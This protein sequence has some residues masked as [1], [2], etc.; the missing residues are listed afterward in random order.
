MK[1]LTLLYEAV[2]HY[3][4]CFDA[5]ALNVATA[6]EGIVK[7]AAFRQS[8]KGALSVGPVK[9]VKYVWPKIQVC[10]VCLVWPSS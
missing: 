5:P 7:P 3:I 4:E 6:L 1:T 10:L 9:G 2:C 8:C